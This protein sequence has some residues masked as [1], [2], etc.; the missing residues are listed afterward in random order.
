MNA[1]RAVAARLSLGSQDAWRRHPVFKW[2]WLDAIPGIR[3]GTALF[4]LYCA[5]EYATAGKG[6][7][8]GHAAAHAAPAAHGD[9]HAAPHDAHGHAPK[10]ALH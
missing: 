1:T 9:A 10:A 7:A 6:D 8:H 2:T 4:A 3:E 5:F